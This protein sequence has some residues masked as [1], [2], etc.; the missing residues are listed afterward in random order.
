LKISGGIADLRLSSLAAPTEQDFPGCKVSGPARADALLEDVKRHAR[1]EDATFVL[2]SAAEAHEP[3]PDEETASEAQSDVVVYDPD[4]LANGPYFALR[5]AR[6]CASARVS[7]HLEEAPGGSEM[8][9]C[10]VDLATAYLGFALMGA[11]SAVQG[12]V[13][14]G[15]YVPAGGPRSRTLII[16]RRQTALRD[17]DWVFALAVFLELRSETADRAL[18]FL[19]EELHDALRHAIVYLR[20]KPDLIPALARTEGST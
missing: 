3:A 15:I 20:S 13:V 8:T 18:K 4:V 5:L 2:M 10:V 19:E 16:D 17:I 6:E 12:Y 9:D 7:S 11:N 14:P 1:A